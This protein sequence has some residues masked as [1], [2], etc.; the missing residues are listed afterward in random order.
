M[1]VAVTVVMTVAVTVTIEFAVTVFVT[2]ALGGLGEMQ[3]TMIR[4]AV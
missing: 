3:T 1:T 4:S 2:V